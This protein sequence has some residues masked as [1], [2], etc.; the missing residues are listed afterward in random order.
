[1]KMA[2]RAGD[3]VVAGAAVEEDGDAADPPPQAGQRGMKRK[4][5]KPT[6]EDKYGLAALAAS[7]PEHQGKKRRKRKSTIEASTVDAATENSGPAASERTALA[8]GS[9]DVERTVFVDGLPY[10][11][12]EDKVRDFFLDC[13][14]VREVRAPKWQDSGRLRGFAHVSFVD[15]ASQDKALALDGS[16]VGKKGRYLKI[17]AAK[18]PNGH[19]N[20]QVSHDKVED[21]KGGRRL[22]VKNLPY[23]ATEL[24]IA[25]V[26]KS[27]GKVREVR[28]PTSFGRCKGFA[29]VE[30]GRTESLLK[31]MQLR[32]VPE[33]RGR[34]L[35]LDADVGS[36]PRAGFHYRPEA[37]E[38]NFVPCARGGHGS[39]ARHAGR[40]GGLAGGRRGGRG[41]SGHVGKPRLF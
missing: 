19:A 9:D 24:E 18:P 5:R 25:E 6:N 8:G 37:F 39:G 20:D 34:A 16:Q 22:F 10:V 36:G 13:G 38:S 32:P 31:A 29:Y 1:L 27:C 4:K 15:K 33:L 2:C 17:E 14:V 21:L 3:R 11:W 41:E 28:V 35:R 30:F 7:Q 23:D 26:F 12:T 40:G